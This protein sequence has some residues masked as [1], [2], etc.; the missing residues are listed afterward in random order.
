[1]L[2][3]CIGLFRPADETDEWGVVTLSVQTGETTVSHC[4][5]K[6]LL[7]HYLFDSY[8]LTK[9]QLINKYLNSEQGKHSQ[10]EWFFTVV[11]VVVQFAVKRD[12][13]TGC[14]VVRVVASCCW[15]EPHELSSLYLWPTGSDGDLWKKSG[16]LQPWKPD[17]W[18]CSWDNS[19]CVCNY[20]K[21]IFKPNY[22]VFLTLNQVLLLLKLPAKHL[23]FLIYYQYAVIRELLREKLN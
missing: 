11:S 6:L 21:S 4:R 18:R 2:N 23:T 7:I 20:Q 1:M 10:L 9:V 13:C 19:S 17:V 14:P 15:W 3:S 5:M 12:G 22:D 16:L 8:Q